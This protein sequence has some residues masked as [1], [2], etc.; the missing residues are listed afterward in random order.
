M[1]DLIE[2]RARR[3]G[4]VLE[5]TVLERSLDLSALARLTRALSERDASTHRLGRDLRLRGYA[6]GLLVDCA[7]RGQ[8][9]DAAFARAFLTEYV[10][11]EYADPDGDHVGE[12][13]DPERFAIP[14]DGETIPGSAFVLDRFLRRCELAAT[15]DPGDA[16]VRAAFEAAGR[17]WQAVP[18]ALRRRFVLALEPVDPELAARFEGETWTAA[19]LP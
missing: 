10:R 11:S 1:T 13:F 14:D 6:L 5:R 4:A 19:Y 15:H 12:E 17:R 16:Q 9:G 2:V 18:D 8:L 3:I 7:A